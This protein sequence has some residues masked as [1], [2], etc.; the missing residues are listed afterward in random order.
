MAE[1]NEKQLMLLDTLVYL[2]CGFPPST[3]VE[4]LVRQ[5][6]EPGALDRLTFDDALTREETEEML[7]YIAADEEL[8][9]LTI[10]DSTDGYV[11]A[12]CFEDSS[13]DAVIAYRGTGGTYVAWDD[14]FQGGYLSE[15]E[16]QQEA[17]EF[18]EGCAVK[19]DDITVT[20]HSK[21][22]NMAQ[23][24]TVVM[25]DEVDRCVSFDGQG[26]SD[27]F[28]E[29]YSDEIEL[30]RSKIRS[31]CSYNDYVNILLTSIAGE[32]VYLDNENGIFPGGHY[33]YDLYTNSNNRLDEN[34]EY[35]TSRE[36][37]I[38]VQGMN[39]LE[40]L[41]VKYLDSTPQVVEFVVYSVFGGV[42]GGLLGKKERSFQLAIEEFVSNLKDFADY[43]FGSALRGEK[44]RDYSFSVETQALR[45]HGDV[46]ARAAQDL[47]TLRS[48]IK[49]VQRR[50]ASN[51]VDGIAIG[52][53]LQQ[54][55]WQLDSEQSKL[56]KM[57]RVVREAADDY[58]RAEDNAKS[59]A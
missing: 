8:M 22:G 50:M 9:G 2:D 11:R 7:R 20:G 13:G 49:S 14:N 27:E 42:I 4:T 43:F 39:G 5:L 36:Q 59:F 31:V 17:L 45:D 15:T 25:G 40:T 51:I 46:L 23:Y 55:L 48:Q 44:P 58:D 24:V 26:F 41:L 53:P 56:E 54:V 19:Y 38:L 37:S 34:G 33:I 18:A 32:T 12:V 6:Q 29:K 35:V 16:L 57:S 10:V 3:S 1:L 30:N 21:G 52:L 28:I 47:E